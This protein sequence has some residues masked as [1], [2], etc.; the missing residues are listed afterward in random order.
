MRELIIDLDAVAKN[1]ETM[2]AKTNGALAMAIVKADA[3]G[4]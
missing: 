4:N 2:R 3:Y 1:L